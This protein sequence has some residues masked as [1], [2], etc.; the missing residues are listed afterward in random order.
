MGVYGDR[1]FPARKVRRIDPRPTRGGPPPPA[2][3]TIREKRGRRRSRCRTC[4]TRGRGPRVPTTLY[5]VLLLGQ[6]RRELGDTVG[7]AF[8]L[9]FLARQASA[10]RPVRL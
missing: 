3:S 9:R 7:S 4:T 6:G 10:A 8:W 1:R 2:P 5:E